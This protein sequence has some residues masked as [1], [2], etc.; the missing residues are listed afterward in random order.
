[1]TILLKRFIED[2]IE[3][4]E[5]NDWDQLFKEWYNLYACV[6]PQIDAEYLKELFKSLQMAGIDCKEQSRDA[7]THIVEE[8]IKEYVVEQ[9]IKKQPYATTV[10]AVNYVQS[11]LG[12]SYSI[13]GK[14]KMIQ[15]VFDS[16]DLTPETE[17]RLKYVIG[18]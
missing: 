12:V 18:D 17:L 13:A 16:L 5:N 9:R 3:Y 7:R 1:M 8:A 6:D 10:G 15:Q 4:I 2:N 11:W 14:V